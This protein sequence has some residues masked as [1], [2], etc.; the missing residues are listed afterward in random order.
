MRVIGGEYKGRTLIVGTGKGLRPTSDRIRKSLFDILG[1][2]VE[3]AQF[4][5]IFAGTGAVGIEALSRGAVRATFIEISRRTSEALRRNLTRLGIAHQAEVLVGDARK[6]LKRLFE[7]GA[8]FDIVFL[9]PP[10]GTDLGKRTL[11]VLAAHG[12]VVRPG[13]WVI[14]QHLSKEALT[15]QWGPLTLAKRRR[16]GEHCLSF[17]LRERTKED[18]KETESFD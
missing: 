18:R 14:V 15:D 10:Y 13:G 12:S 11:E 7:R 4:L 3:G 9:D 16:I 17:Y 8:F 6:W 5:D 2:E 1:G